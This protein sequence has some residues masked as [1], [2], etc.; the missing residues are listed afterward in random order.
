M[1]HSFIGW[2]VLNHAAV[3]DVIVAIAS[4]IIVCGIQKIDSTRAM[5]CF[6]LYIVK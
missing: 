2:N 3:V 5:R 1:M 4:I 6:V